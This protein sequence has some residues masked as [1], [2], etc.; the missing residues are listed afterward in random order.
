MHWHFK[1]PPVRVAAAALLEAAP[2]GFLCQELLSLPTATPQMML[3]FSIWLLPPLAVCSGR[4]HNSS[5]SPFSAG[6]LNLIPLPF[7]LLSNGW[8]FLPCTVGWRSSCSALARAGNVWAQV[9]FMGS[10]SLEH[11]LHKGHCYSQALSLALG[12]S[13]LPSII[14]GW[15][16]TAALGSCLSQPLSLCLSRPAQCA[17]RG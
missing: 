2:L 9:G 16:R 15:S 10:D 7:A 12:S 4:E 6:Q 11:R 8:Q 17:A 5:S 3:I 13:L 1:N 14:L